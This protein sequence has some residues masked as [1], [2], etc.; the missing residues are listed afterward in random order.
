[1]K[2]DKCI[3]NISTRIALFEK[4]DLLLNETVFSWLATVQCNVTRCELIC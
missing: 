1:M 2:L 4:N 3:V